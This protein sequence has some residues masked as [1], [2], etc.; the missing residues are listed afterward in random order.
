MKS[1]FLDD[2]VMQKNMPASAG[3][4]ALDSFVS[5]IDSEAAARLVNNGYTIAGRVKGC[6]FGFS[7]VFSNELEAFDIVKQ[8]AEGRACFGLVNDV[9]GFY[10]MR[11]AESNLFCIRPTYGRVSRYGLIQSVP[12]TD[13]L[14]IICDDISGGFEALS[15]ISGRDEKDGAMFKEIPRGLHVP[16]E[17]ITV[18]VPE[19][20]LKNASA[21][22]QRAARGF[23]KKFDA[24]N[25]EIIYFNQMKHVIYILS[26]A[27]LSASL[28][29]YDGL[30]F[31]Y[32]SKDGEGLEDLYVKSRSEAFGLCVKLA[33]IV[34]AAVLS[35]ENYARHYEKAMRIRR[36]IK[37]SLDFAGY[38]AVILPGAINGCAYENLSLGAVSRLAGLPAV[39]FN[40]DGIGLQLIGGV[41]N[42]DLL[43]E[44]L[45]RGLA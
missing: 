6:E 30:N 8:I 15:V 11:A 36:L 3:S 25:I 31:G 38:D 17:K 16:R 20:I 18:G 4:R 7:D 33:L 39:S 2:C 40:Y 24:T 45:K 37:Q 35:A 5:L 10:G 12:S 43:F 1:V 28:A 27:E 14:G 32:A 44:I 41:N 19:E 22:A 21:D 23:I 26:C 9:F 13:Q 34:G 42:E 29:R